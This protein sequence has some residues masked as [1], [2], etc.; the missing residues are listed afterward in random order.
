M[1][2]IE[3]TQ[4]PGTKGETW[5]TIRAKNRASGGLGHF[6]EHVSEGCRNCYAERLQPRFRNRDDETSSRKSLSSIP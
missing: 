4:R 1:T 2:T 5:N 6:C 3:W